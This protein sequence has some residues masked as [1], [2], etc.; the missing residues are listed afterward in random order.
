M[1][2]LSYPACKSHA[3]HYSHLW[4]VWF[5]HIFSRYLINGSFRN[6]KLL[7]IKYVFIFSMS[8]IWNIS[9]DKN[10]TRH[11]H[12]CIC[13]HIKCPL[14]S[15]CNEKWISSTD[16]WKNTKISN[17]MKIAAVEAEFIHAYGLFILH[18]AFVIIYTNKVPTV[19]PYT[20]HV[21]RISFFW[22][23]RVR[24][25]R[26]YTYECTYCVTWTHQHRDTHNAVFYGGCLIHFIKVAFSYCT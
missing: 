26:L 17:F 11:Y 3:P 16:F 19:R 20:T 25:R 2:S 6:K 23:E 18:T 1:C 7:N 8:F 5:Y 15:D 21:T 12:K 9:H 14:L 13:L 22:I 24:P 4:R 10:L